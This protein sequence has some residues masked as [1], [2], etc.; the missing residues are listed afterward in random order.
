M[1]G[2]GAVLRSNGRLRLFRRKSN[3]PGYEDFAGF[4]SV[5]VWCCSILVFLKRLKALINSCCSSVVSFL[6]VRSD[7]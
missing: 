4:I 3:V 2:H 7:R 5:T 1:T 6:K